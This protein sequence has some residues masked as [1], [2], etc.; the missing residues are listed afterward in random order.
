M[1]TGRLARHI[2]PGRGAAQPAANPGN[3][4]EQS[5][6]E[7]K[8]REQNARSFAGKSSYCTAIER[9]PSPCQQKQGGRQKNTCEI[10]RFR[11]GEDDRPLSAH[12]Y[13]QGTHRTEVS[14]W[15][16]IVGWQVAVL[17]ARKLSLICFRMD[18]EDRPA[19]ERDGHF[20][21]THDEEHPWRMLAI[22]QCD[23]RKK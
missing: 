18:R 9:A 10:E 2:V 12:C 5:H 14:Y 21:E 17:P 15:L 8:H 11:D 16:T 3:Q 22:E 20:S 1:S 13:D 23:A 6:E 19:T 7:G 4:R